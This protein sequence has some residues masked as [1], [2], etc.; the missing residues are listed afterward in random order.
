MPKVVVETTRTGE[1]TNRQLA[2]LLWPLFRP[3]LWHFAG[4]LVLLCLHAALLIAGPLLVK[5]AIDQDITKGDFAGL[6]QTV[7]LFLGVQIGAMTSAYLMRNWLEWTGQNMMAALR[8]QLFD[9]LLKLPL[10]FHDRYTP[11]QLLSRL[12]SDTQA[13]RMLFTTTTVTLLGSVLMFFGMF[14]VMILVSPRLTAVAAAV[15]P[16]M[17]AI[18]IYFQRRIHPLFVDVRRQ[19][20]ILTGRLTEFLQALPAIRTFNRRRWATADLQQLNYDKYETGLKAQSLI[21]LWFNLIAWLQSVAIA[22]IIGAGGYWALLGLVQIGTLA[23][24][25]GYV[26]RFFEPLMRLSEQLATIQKAFAS[27]ERIFSLLKQP[28]HIDDPAEPI[29]WPGLRSEV[30]FE[31][32]WFRYGVRRNE[33]EATHAAAVNGE[34]E[35]DDW[36]LR[37]LSFTL[38]AGE[39]WALVG[40]T[41]SGKTTIVSLLLR[42]YEPQRGRITIDG[43]DIRAM[44]QQDLRRH[45]GMVLQ[46]I[47]LFPGDLTANL[48][49]GTAATD[50]DLR[51][52]AEVSLADRFIRNLPGGYHAELAERGANLSL[53]QRQLLSFTRAL[54]RDPQLLVLDEATSAVDPA[55]EATLTLATRRLLAGRTGLV[56]A[57]RLST[58]RECDNI[59]VLQHGRLIEQGTHEELI[60]HGGLYDALHKLQDTEVVEVR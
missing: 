18:T 17:F 56:I 54:L 8:R 59:L 9:H 1:F 27:A 44:R 29:A 35:D 20:A 22:L 49:L 26:R 47:Y 5:Q 4:S 43:V 23:L 2:R 32:V 10:T 45:I 19:N 39:T 50:D 52:A 11:G 15:L 24:F 48:T 40:P 60:V 51:R 3:H 7:L 30:R 55:T 6:R 16:V 25:V 41:G 31:H 42:F 14:T 38:P 36:V 58:I 53:G 33:E 34:P 37:D 57:H 13:L 28:L 12:E 21:V 46:D